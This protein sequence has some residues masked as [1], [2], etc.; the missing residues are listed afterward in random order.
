MDPC[1][2]MHALPDLITRAD[3][4]HAPKV[5]GRRP[6]MQYTAGSRERSS[7][8]VKL[9]RW[10]VIHMVVYSGSMA[11]RGRESQLLLNPSPITSTQLTSSEH[12]FSA[13]GPMPNAATLA[14]C[15]PR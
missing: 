6:L 14:C 4:S 10:K 9:C 11:L 13:R 7:I 3:E 15:S 2:A 1:R 8:Q 5:P 12:H